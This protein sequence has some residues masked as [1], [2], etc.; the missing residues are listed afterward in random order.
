MSKR[1]FTVTAALPYSNGCLHVGHIA[2]CYLPADTYVRYLRSHGDEVAFICGSDDYGVP[3]TLTARKENKTPREVNDYY[4]D[5]QKKDFDGLGVKFDI[6]SGT[7]TPI[8]TRFTQEFFL[9]VLENGHLEKR[10]QKQLYDPE[11]EMFLPDRYVE[12]VCH[13]CGADGARGDQCESCGK[14]IE[15]TLL[16]EPHSMIS[17][18][19]PEVRETVHWFF[20]LSEFEDRL[21]DWIESHEE[22]RPMV[23]NFSRGLLGVGLPD[24]T[25]TRDL[26]WGVPVPLA[27]DPDASGKVLYVWFDAPIGYVSF[28]AEWCE[29]QGGHWTDYERWWKDPDSKIVHFIGEDNVVFHALMWPAMLMAEGSYQLPDNVAANCFLNIQFPGEEEQKM[30]TSRGTAIWI[31]EYLADYD[32]DPLRYYLTMVAPEGQRTA[33]QFDDLITRNNDELVATLGNLVHR[34]VTFVHKYH[35]G[36]VPERG[37][38]TEQDQRQL[39]LAVALPDT[40]SEQIEGYHFKAAMQLVMAAAKESNRY[41]DHCQPWVRRKQDM[42]ACGTTINVLLNTIKTLGVVMEPFL[43]FAAEKVARMLSCEAD[44]LTWADATGLLP[45]GRALGEPGILF[46]KLEPPSDRQ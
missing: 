14:T 32:P 40:V 23:R 35:G 33:F 41:F 25:I 2:G 39:D 45:E 7:T 3:I 8:H 29:R 36:R 26:D 11:A 12:G 34:T 22:W 28:T 10:A 42:A 37:Q 18:A 17:G 30:S 4:R 16:G 21:R 44:E 15:P 13:H 1:R 9:K 5:L 46:V 31:R 6:Y 24:R 43:P 38:T 20:K 27:D 19:T